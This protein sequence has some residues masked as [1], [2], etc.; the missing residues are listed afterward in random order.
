MLEELAESLTVD[1]DALRAEKSGWGPPPESIYELSEEQMLAMLQDSER[2]ERHDEMQKAI[3]KL[4]ESNDNTKMK[5]TKLAKDK[6]ELLSITRK[7]KKKLYESNLTN[8]KLLYTNKVLMNDSLNERQKT[9]IAEALSNANT[10]EEAR[11]IYETLQSAT[12]V[13]VK[14][15]QP[16]SLNE[17]VN[18][19]VS[20]TLILSHRK[21]D[22]KEKTQNDSSVERWKILAGLNNKQ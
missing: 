15:E 13:P 5:N 19:K 21:R 4:Q 22:M 20:S 2:R 12:G 6:K 1:I 14:K 3:N 8:S 11:T 10:V 7:M 16:E 17:A 9:R 18:N